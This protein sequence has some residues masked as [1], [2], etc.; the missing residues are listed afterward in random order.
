MDDEHA[1]TSKGT[2]PTPAMTTAAPP[3]ST[4]VDIDAIVGSYGDLPTVAP[5]AMQVIEMVDDEDVTVQK[6]A[7]VI[8]T[9]PGL[10]ARLLKLANSA[11]YSRGQPVTDVSRAAMLLGLRTLKM[12]TLGFTLIDRPPAG[13]PA[14][15]ALTWRRSLATA[16]LGRKMAV[17]V[18]A[19][20]SEDGFT[21]GLLS[22]VGKTALLDEPAYLEAVERWGPWLSPETERAVLG[23]TSDELTGRLLDAWNLPVVLGEGVWSRHPEGPEELPTPLGSALRLADH[24]AMLILGDPDDAAKA[25]DACTLA[26]AHLG[27]TIDEVERMVAMAGPE[28]DELAGSF[29]LEA[30]SPESMDD[31][32]R[33]AQ[34]RLAA[35]TLDIASQLSEEQLRNDELV[36]TNQELAEAASTDA[37]TGLPNRRT[38]DAFLAN[39]VASRVRHT[40]ES[41][42]GLVLFDLDKFKVIN[43]THGHAVGD[44]VL[45]TVG[46][47]MAGGSRRG[48]LAART[49]G[50]EF[51]LIMPEI[52]PRDLEGATER[53]RRLLADAPIDTAVGPL[54]VTC[55]LGAAW[56]MELSEGDEKDLYER[57]DAA[58]YASKEAGRNR[59]TLD[60]PV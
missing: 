5:I 22:N 21:G 10:T 7:D 23:F 44:E 15:S 20:L 31:I 35:I 11:A 33:S 12:V 54:T 40:R 8:S 29:D 24:A 25:L 41:A 17:T 9:D 58:L 47:R 32:V 56:S 53:L 27:L 60:P 43:D 4:A 59:Y 14:L 6:L 19:E 55:S 39:Q 48:E 13:N 34:S 30:I 26:A 37:L 49:G 45:A 18:A 46:Q 36:E 42:L 16:V 57:A 3:P 38:F 2:E 28:L 1:A 51:A 52:S 50:E